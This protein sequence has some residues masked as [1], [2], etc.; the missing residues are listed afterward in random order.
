[1]DG[2]GFTREGLSECGN[3]DDHQLETVC[4]GSSVSKKKGLD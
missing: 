2:R 4:D 1:V 3:D